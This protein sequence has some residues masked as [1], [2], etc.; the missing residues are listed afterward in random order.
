VK[1]YEDELH[2]LRAEV[3]ANRLTHRQVSCCCCVYGS[4][5]AAV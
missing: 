3:S 1:E 4:G 2:A 5:R